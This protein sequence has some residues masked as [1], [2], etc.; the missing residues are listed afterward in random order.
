MR[1][2]LKT[3]R[4]GA[5]LR[6][7]ELAAALGIS[8]AYYCRLEHGERKLSLQMLGKLAIATGENVYLLCDEEMK[9]QEGRKEESA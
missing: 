5:G 8:E 6:M 1:S 7:R 3:L 4:E 9:F 2:Y